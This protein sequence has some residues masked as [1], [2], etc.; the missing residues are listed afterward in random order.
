[1]KVLVTGISGFIGSHVAAALAALGHRVT[2]TYRG[3]PPRILDRYRDGFRGTHV[4]GGTIDA[5]RADLSEA[6]EIAPLLQD[7][8]AIVHIAGF[9]LDWGP[10][11][12]FYRANVLP[13]EYILD[14]LA[15]HPGETRLFIHTSSLSVHGFG[16]QRGSDEAGPYYPLITHY[17]RSKLESEELMQAAGKSAACA[18]GIIRPGNAYGPGDTTTMYPMLDAIRAGKM[19]L[20][21]RG[22]HLTCP[23]FIDDLVAAYLALFEKLADADTDPAEVPVYNITGGEDISW[24]QLVE[25]ACGAADLPFPRLQVPGWLA[26]AAAMAMSGAYR[27]AGAKHPP[28]LTRYRIQQVSHDYHFRMDKA[29]SELGWQPLIPFAQ[30]IIETAAAWREHEIA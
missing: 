9:A 16:H 15:D 19:G 11:E 25:Q 4:P 21:N 7:A 10:A 26:M 6:E 8:E 13:V 27:L 1:M 24:R 12:R 28:D 22:R 23:V 14:Y 2:G 20:V 17:Q 30:G 18:M 3:N 5:V 29:Q